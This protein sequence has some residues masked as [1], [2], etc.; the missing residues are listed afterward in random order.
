[1]NVYSG[2]CLNGKCGTKTPII[3]SCDSELFVG[4]IV[5][6]TKIGSYHPSLTVIV[7]GRYTT[8]S[9]GTIKDKGVDDFFIMGIKNAN[10]NEWIIK[11][12]KS[13]KDVI[14]GENWKA[15]GFNYKSN[16]GERKCL[17]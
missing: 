14:D 16:K 7:N 6:I 13:Y 9:D 10:L 17:S 3:D 11:K 8:Y 2:N 4:D 1:M 15:F 12:A 5:I